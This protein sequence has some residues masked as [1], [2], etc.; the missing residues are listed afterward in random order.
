MMHDLDPREQDVVRRLTSAPA[1]LSGETYDAAM[2]AY[3]RS[4][5]GRRGH[6]RRHSVRLA[7]VATVTVL[8]GSLAAGYAA[9]LPDPVQRAAHRLLAHVG[10]PAPHH[11]PRQDHGH[12]AAV[13][14][15]PD[16]DGGSSRQPRPLHSAPDAHARFIALD[17]VRE[18]A[19]SRAV[20]TVRTSEQG[21]T[22]VRLESALTADGPWHE[23]ASGR[24]YRG[25]GE[26]IVPR[27]TRNTW[28]RVA[29]GGA[30]SEPQLAEVVPLIRCAWTHR[31]SRLELEIVVDGARPGDKVEVRGGDQGRTRVLRARIDSR[32]RVTVVLD[33]PS[34][35]TT[36]T[37]VVPATSTHADAVHLTT[38]PGPAPR[39]Q[40]T[41]T[42]TPS[43]TPTAAPSH[44][45]R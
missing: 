17:P 43:A 9:A 16:A 35:R 41:P 45:P 22:W 10:V 1:V 37:V 24:A 28:L 12:P 5:A 38:S 31:G 20:A 29:G 39:S 4:R 7:T 27:L 13:A 34:T 15:R 33:A 40:P 25:S 42:P 26:V 8:T 36:W 11:H 32:G 44:E 6:Y 2:A 3:R 19:G 18:V 14:T 30:V 21:A 23:T